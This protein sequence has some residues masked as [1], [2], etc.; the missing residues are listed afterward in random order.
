MGAGL[1]LWCAFNALVQDEPV[2][3]KRSPEI[4][5]PHPAFHPGTHQRDSPLEF[6][7]V[8]SMWARRRFQCVDMRPEGEERDPCTSSACWQMLARWPSP[9]A[10]CTVRGAKILAWLD[11]A[12]PRPPA[13]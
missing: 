5:H 1:L 12:G 3:M 2:R 9:C 11:T 13:L 4:Q 10:W 8:C 7:W 6:L